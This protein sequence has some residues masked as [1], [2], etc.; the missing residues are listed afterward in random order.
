MRYI[1]TDNFNSLSHFFIGVISYLSPNMISIIICVI[2]ILYQI[3]TDLILKKN[4]NYIIDIIEFYIGFYILFCYK[5]F[6][7]NNRQKM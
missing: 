3:I 5:N 2:F 6:K 1:F 4:D 7:D